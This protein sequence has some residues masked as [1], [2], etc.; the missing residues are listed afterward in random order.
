MGF[1]EHLQRQAS[2]A[3]VYIHL[4]P[5]LQGLG[6]Q[7]GIPGLQSE[8]KLRHASMTATDGHL[9]KMLEI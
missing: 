2:W 3:A 8:L 4:L 7:G 9:G 5:F 1:S 6:T